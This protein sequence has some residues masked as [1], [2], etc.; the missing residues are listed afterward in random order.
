MVYGLYRCYGPLSTNKR[1]VSWSHE[2]GDEEAALF[3]SRS[4][5]DGETWIINMPS[6]FE[7]DSN[8]VPPNG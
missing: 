2:L 6:L 4:F 3:F 7:R 1:R 8:S 5:T